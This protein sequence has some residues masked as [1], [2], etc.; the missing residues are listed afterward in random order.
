MK[1]IVLGSNGRL[2]RKLCPFLKKKGHIVYEFFRE[3]E[4][5]STDNFLLNLEKLL[6]NSRINVIINLVALT[7]I[8]KCEIDINAAYNS[9]ILTLK[10]II[11]LIAKKDIH[12]IHIST[13][14][15]YSGKGPHLE[16]HI[17]PLNVYGLTKYFSE[18]IA[19]S[20]NSTI[21]RTN[22][23]GKSSTEKNISLSDWIYQS[24]INKSEITLFKNIL[25]S[26]LYIDDLCT[27]L[28]LVSIK[29]IN[30][31][32]N[33]GSRGHISKAKFGLRLAEG[34][35]LNFKKVSLKNYDS[36][37]KRPLDMSLDCSKFE[38]NFEII[39]PDISKTVNNAIDD[40]KNTMA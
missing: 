39:L 33:L 25:F 24:L 34:L 17:S 26:P 32:F 1:I 27:I 14:Q 5:K 36:N 2:G 19:S 13:D 28:E 23:I 8:N 20:V 10:N 11:P 29:Q 30:G 6:N 31:T 7:D 22:Y 9:N 3:K 15:V 40:Y 12:L 37:I 38:K 4:N 18:I 16:N 21:L 35:D